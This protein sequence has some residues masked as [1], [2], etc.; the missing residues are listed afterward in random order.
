[1]QQKLLDFLKYES[2]VPHH[3]LSM[4]CVLCAS[5]HID[6]SLIKAKHS[7]ISRKESEFFS[8]G[9]L[10]FFYTCNKPIKVFEVLY[11]SSNAFGFDEQNIQKKMSVTT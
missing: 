4:F 10:K 11:T 3:V 2:L 6:D 1:M 8:T 5:L 9:S 7:F